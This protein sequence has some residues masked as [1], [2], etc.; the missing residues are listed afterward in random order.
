MAVYADIFPQTGKIPW[1]YSHGRG[2]SKMCV[3]HSFAHLAP[4]G[5]SG[6]TNENKIRKDHK[7]PCLSH[8]CGICLSEE[9]GGCH[10]FCPEKWEYCSGVTMERLFWWIFGWRDCGFAIFGGWDCRKAIFQKLRR[11]ESN[12]SLRQIATII[13]RKIIIKE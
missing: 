1:I 2:V 6:S 9:R 3:W 4:R 11:R 8:F 12:L 10:F 5:D 13:Q 7:S